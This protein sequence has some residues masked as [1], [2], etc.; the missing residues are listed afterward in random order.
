MTAHFREPS[1]KG[2]SAAMPIKAVESPPSGP[3]PVSMKRDDDDLTMFARIVVSESQAP[4]GYKGDKACQLEEPC[5]AVRGGLGPVHLNSAIGGPCG[6]N[7][8]WCSG[9]RSLGCGLYASF[10]GATSQS[11]W[12]TSRTLAKYISQGLIH[13][14]LRSR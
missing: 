11:E 9:V 8:R 12:R 4:Q 10:Q 13:H 2:K 14:F 3:R 7:R 1:Q 6:A 5:A